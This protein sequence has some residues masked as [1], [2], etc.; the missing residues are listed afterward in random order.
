MNV[1]FKKLPILSLPKILNFPP[2]S[3]CILEENINSAVKKGNY[4]SVAQNGVEW[5]VLATH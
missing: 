4:K 5:Q 3:P 1:L 2:K